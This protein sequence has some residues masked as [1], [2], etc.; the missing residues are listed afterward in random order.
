VERVEAIIAIND[1]SLEAESLFIPEESNEKLY[2]RMQRIQLLIGQGEIIKGAECLL[3][4]TAKRR[5]SC[6]TYGIEDIEWN[7]DSNI[8]NRPL[9]SCEDHETIGYAR[10]I[11][12]LQCNMWSKIK[13]IEK[14]N[15]FTPQKTIFKENIPPQ[16]IQQISPA[17]N[18]ENAAKPLLTFSKINLD[19]LDDSD[20]DDD[21][22][23]EF[24][25]ILKMNDKLQEVRTKN[26]QPDISDKDRRR[27]AETAAKDMMKTLQLGSDSSSGEGDPDTME[28]A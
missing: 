9:S 5:E 19:L 16:E 4:F 27:N 20:T 26:T 21:E 10:I 24:N 15:Q 12:A 11:E 28:G 8:D 23:R 18:P 7:D 3:P 25:R 6:L 13:K 1:G 2:E 22:L 14:M 17:P